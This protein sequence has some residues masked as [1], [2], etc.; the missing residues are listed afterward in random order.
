MYND[1][2]ERAYVWY[3]IKI[4]R[5]VGSFVIHI[6]RISCA[7][8]ASRGAGFCANENTVVRTKV[9]NYATHRKIWHHQ[10][11]ALRVCAVVIT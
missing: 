3:K 4:T 11:T 6:P 5:N 7:A 2:I 10:I 8:S 9:V 1:T